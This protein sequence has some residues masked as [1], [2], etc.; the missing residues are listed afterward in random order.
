MKHASAFAAIT[1]PTVNSYKRINAPRTMSGATWAPNSVTW[2]GNN[3]THMVR[4][5][6]PGRFELRLADGATNPYLLQAVII[7]AG[8]SGVKS[9]A[10]PGKRYDI[11]MYAQGH[12]VRGAPKLPLNMLDALRAY[13]K[14][15]VL[16]EA[17]GKEFSDA[18]LKLKMEEWNSFVSH[19]SSWEKDNT[20]D[21]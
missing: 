10:D 21:I 11:D 14:D 19:F 3:R 2:T 13:D 9:E 16:K 18:Y 17:M 4:V 12:T 1:N 7:A 5:P 8:L 15:K 6:G 20:L